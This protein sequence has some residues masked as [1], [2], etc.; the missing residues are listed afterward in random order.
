MSRSADLHPARQPTVV[1]RAEL[2][3]AGLISYLRLASVL[4]VEM[5]GDR[6]DSIRAFRAAVPD[7]DVGLIASGRYFVADCGGELI[8]GVGWSVLPLRFGGEGLMTEDG[9]STALWLDP[10]AVLMRGFFVDPDIGRGQVAAHLLAHAE[11]DAARAGHQAC[12]IVAPSSAQII[13][14]SLGFRPARRLAVQTDD[15]PLPVVQMRK[16]VPVRLKSAA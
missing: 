4:S 1:R 14:R 16:R 11:A 7:V 10:D 12:E 13:Y 2:S 5:P 3:E 8:G 15:G 9:R 6:L